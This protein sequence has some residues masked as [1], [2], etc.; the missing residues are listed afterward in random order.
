V[1]HGEG[2]SVEQLRKRRPQLFQDPLLGDLRSKDW[3]EKRLVRSPLAG[4]DLYITEEV[5]KEYSDSANRF[6]NEIAVHFEVH[7]DANYP[8]SG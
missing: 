5:F 2:G 8:H 6:V 7:G 4:E 3:S 1:K